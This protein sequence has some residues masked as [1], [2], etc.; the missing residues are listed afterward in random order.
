VQKQELILSGLEDEGT[1]QQTRQ[2]P[3]EGDNPSGSIFR[4]K[5]IFNY[6]FTY[7]TGLDAGLANVDGKTFSHFDLGDCD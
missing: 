6:F 7:V 2:I 4:N 3:A 5:A 1:R